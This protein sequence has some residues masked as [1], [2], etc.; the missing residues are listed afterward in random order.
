MA[1][2]RVPADVMRGVLFEFAGVASLATMAC[3]S[4]TLCELVE[5]LFARVNVVVLDP[6]RA[7]VPTENGLLDEERMLAELLR[8]CWRCL[9]E[10]TWFYV[11]TTQY[12]T[13]TLGT[14]ARQRLWRACDLARVIH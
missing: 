5:T 2:V 4:K 1:L 11:A 9:P 3:T 13:A 12:C 8:A 7:M 14:I 6:A 10:T